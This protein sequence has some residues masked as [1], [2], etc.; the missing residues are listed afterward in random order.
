[1]PLR[2]IRLV[3]QSYCTAALPVISKLRKYDS[4]WGTVQTCRLETCFGKHLWRQPPWRR[5]RLRCVLCVW[6]NSRM[7]C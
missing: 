5:R 2:A 1:M 4:H 3:S 6:F 7:H